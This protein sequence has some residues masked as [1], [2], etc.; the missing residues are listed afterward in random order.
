MN[1][2]KRPTRV[3]SGALLG[4]AVRQLDKLH[5]KLGLVADRC[6]EGGEG[7][8]A[9]EVR[10]AMRQITNTT[11]LAKLYISGKPLPTLASVRGILKQPN[12]KS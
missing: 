4:C 2:K 8:I 5:D 6:D 7:R 11:D 12:E 10:Q 3:A 1:K 9:F